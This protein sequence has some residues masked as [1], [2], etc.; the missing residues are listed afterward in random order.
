MAVNLVFKDDDE[1]MIP[2]TKSNYSLP[3]KAPK[4]PDSELTPSQVSFSKSTRSDVSN[5]HLTEIYLSL[6]NEIE[7]EE[8]IV[9]QLLDSEIDVS[10]F[11]RILKMS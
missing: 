3:G 5:W 8:E 9:K 4:T 1:N 10:K 11:K 7:D 2:N 6:N